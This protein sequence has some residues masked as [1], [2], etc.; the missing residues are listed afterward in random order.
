MFAK[1]CGPN[2]DTSIRNLWEQQAGV[3]NWWGDLCSI[4]DDFNVLDFR[5]TEQETP[6]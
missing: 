1:V 3:Y 4:G 6:G 2:V 5:A